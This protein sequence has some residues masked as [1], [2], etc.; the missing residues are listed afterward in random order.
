MGLF[1]RR[2]GCAAFAAIAL[3]G[4]ASIASAADMPIKAPPV[5]AAPF[6][7]T[8]PYVG[9]NVGVVWGNANYDAICPGA[10]TPACPVLLP[11]SLQ[12]VSG[13]GF[14]IVPGAFAGLPGGSA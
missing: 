14:I 13:I 7:W 5:V 6:S 12:H 4:F 8:G 9:V 3:I 10:V 11:A 1:M 2:F